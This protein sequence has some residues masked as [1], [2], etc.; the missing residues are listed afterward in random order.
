MSTQSQVPV[1]A[2]E[3][4]ALDQ[5]HF[6]FDQGRADAAYRWLRREAPMWWFEPRRFWV[7]SRLSDIQSMSQQPDVWSSKAGII[8]PSGEEDPVGVGSSPSIIQMDP[9]QHNRHRSLVSRAFT[10]RRVADMEARMRE[11]AVQSI[12]GSPT[13]TPFD[14]VE[15]IALPLPMRVI[16]EM[17]G[18][19]EDEMENFRRWSDAV[20]VQAGADADRVTGMEAVGEVFAY[21]AEALHKRRAK[22]G[23][24]LIS[25]LLAAE[26]DGRSLDEGEILVFCMTLLVAG[27]ETTRTFVSQGTRLLLENPAQLELLR[28]GAVALPDALEEILRLVTPIRYFFRGATRDIEMHGMKVRAGDP[29]MLLYAAANRDETVWGEDADKLD[30]KRPLVPHVSLGFGQHFCL[31]ASLAR[32]EARVLFEELLARRSH[33]EI[34][35]DVEF[36]DSSF[37]NGIGKM[38]MVLSI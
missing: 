18:V 4:I 30:L 26:V 9:P 29:V 28:S 1:P 27:N 5:G 24:D 38:P 15:H 6:Y 33:W 2:A 34:A 3:S 17:L 36:V 22:P 37:I 7:A 11:I 35:G 25:A 31:G 21:F 13:G 19:P 10:P 20:V 8:M 14:F 23:N 12:E 32:L 16:A